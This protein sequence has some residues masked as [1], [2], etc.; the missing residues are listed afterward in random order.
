MKRLAL[1]LLLAALGW[2]GS[3][4][5][6]IPSAH[7]QVA[8]PADREA[9]VQSIRNAREDLAS[10]RARYEGARKAYSKMK[11]HRRARGDRK[12]AL[13]QERDE[14]AE[15]LAQ[16][17]RRLEQLLESARRAGVPPGWV[18]EAMEPT[19]DPADQAGD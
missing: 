5:A 1:A 9:W 10:A 12:E 4:P 14:A 6:G 18:R 16:A 15:A 3:A 2:A 8:T 7:T 11:H 13:V 19:S 17:E